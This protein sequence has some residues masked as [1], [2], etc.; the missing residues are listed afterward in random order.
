MSKSSI[1]TGHD[2]ISIPRASKDPAGAPATRA[3][4]APPALM[5]SQ[6]DQGLTAA[7]GLRAPR[8]T[9]VR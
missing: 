7:W 3:R 5:A 1:E 9:L 2:L 6:G 8:G 4:E